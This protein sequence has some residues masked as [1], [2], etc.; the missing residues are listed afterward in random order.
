MKDINYAY[1]Q[2]AHEVIHLLAPSGGENANILEEGLATYFSHLVMR[3]IFQRSDIN[4]V[5]PSYINACDKV[6]ELLSF[7]AD[8]IKK[9]RSVESNFYK[10]TAETFIQAKVDVPATLKNELVLKFKR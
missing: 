5:L 8:A 10:M 2:L 7:D 3:E 9:L 6:T 4:S 1:F